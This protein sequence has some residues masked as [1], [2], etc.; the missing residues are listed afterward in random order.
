[1]PAV[2]WRHRARR[3]HFHLHVGRQGF[4]LRRRIAQRPTG[5]LH[6]GSWQAARRLF[7][8]MHETSSRRDRPASGGFCCTAILAVKERPAAGVP[9][10]RAVLS[11]PAVVSPLSPCG[12]VCTRAVSPA[13]PRSF[14]KRETERPRADKTAGDQPHNRGKAAA[15]P[16]G[17]EK[18]L[19]PGVGMVFSPWPPSK[20]LPVWQIPP[21]RLREKYLFKIFLKAGPPRPAGGTA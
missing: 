20:G 3:L 21:L 4:W 19:A 5:A 12:P 8:F 15:R 1:M 9:C 7:Y 2:G 13:N 11:C 6:V 18:L 10:R 17:S 16:L 14:S